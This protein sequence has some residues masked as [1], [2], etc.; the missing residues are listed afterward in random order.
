MGINEDR[1]RLAQEKILEWI[2]RELDLD[3]CVTVCQTPS[4]DSQDGSIYSTL[5]P[6]DKVEYHRSHLED[7]MPP[8]GLVVV[9]SDPDG[10]ETTG[11]DKDQNGNQYLIID[12]NSGKI[13]GKEI[14]QDFRL[15]YDLYPSKDTSKYVLEDFVT[16]EE[17]AIAI[18]EPNSVK[19]RFKELCRFLKSKKLYLSLRFGYSEYSE[20]SL[21]ELGISDNEVESG[22]IELQD[23]HISWRRVYRETHKDGYQTECSLEARWLIGYAEIPKNKSGF[24]VGIDKYGNEI[25][26]HPHE[27]ESAIYQGPGWSPNPIFVRFKRG[28]LDKYY[29]RDS[30][31][32]VGDLSLIWHDEGDVKHFLPIDDDHDDEVWVLF[33][34]LALLSDEELPHWE[35]HNICPE[36]QLS[37]TYIN[38]YAPG[39]TSTESKQPH[40]QFRN[41]YATLSQSCRSRLGWNLLLP[42]RPA[43]EYRL[44]CLR[45]LSSDEQ[46]DFDE[47]VQSLATILIDSL[48][49][50]CLKKLVSDEEQ[51]KL[52]CREDPPRSLD[53]LEAALRS[54]NV[55]SA[56]NHIS[57]F[58]KLQQLRSSGSAHR[59]GRK[60]EKQMDKNF[61]IKN[62]KYREGFAK[63]L[64]QAVECLEFLTR[65][66]EGGELT[67]KKELLFLY[68]LNEHLH[69][70]L[71]TLFPSGTEG[72]F[73]DET[74]INEIDPETSHIAS[75]L[76]TK[77]IGKF[78]GSPL[79][80]KSLCENL[81]ASMN[82]NISPSD[83]RG[84]LT[85]IAKV[86]ISE[87]GSNLPD[88]IN[89]LSDARKADMQLTEFFE[90]VAG[91]AAYCKKLVGYSRVL[92]KLDEV[93]NCAWY[94]YYVAWYL[95]YASAYTL[96]T[97]EYVWHAEELDSVPVVLDA[98][99][100]V[101]GAADVAEKLVNV[102]GVRKA[103]HDLVRV[104]KCKSL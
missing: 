49:Q 103:A 9:F 90:H 99:S 3:E 15:F 7:Y 98:V 45:V 100:A 72:V 19:I 35:M 83:I 95:S 18:V 38:H 78:D 16:K 22:E 80:F 62:Q 76:R 67:G 6:L 5:I 73:A 34:S 60:Y 14:C 2:Q 37:E 82:P 10:Q 74:W 26:R 59:K 23:G 12:R 17:V 28:V 4:D 21:S 13:A 1:E 8:S 57:F 64:R 94:P 71:E 36:G 20:H 51:E 75:K 101:Q 77:V 102:D 84:A 81:M 30:R 41:R 29:E 93:K 58:R 79:E 27:L 66:V 88:G 43:D 25:R 24:I 91:K 70:L 86:F 56:E 55:A 46:K 44:R 52:D 92:I 68:G 97:Y 32:I 11:I 61:G 63:I 53:Y 39:R 42:L 47:L 50:E 87:A 89:L 85:D 48:N 54:C 104:A 31:Y 96:Y 40:H 69:A 65:V 33:N